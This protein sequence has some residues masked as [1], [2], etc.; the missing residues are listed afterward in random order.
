MAD[1]DLRFGD[2]AGGGGSPDGP[3]E[4]MQMYIQLALQGLVL[5]V[6]LYAVVSVLNTLV[7]DGAL[8][9]VVV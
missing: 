5:L 6:I 3:V 7:L 8:P 9:L 1:D 2:L 4:R